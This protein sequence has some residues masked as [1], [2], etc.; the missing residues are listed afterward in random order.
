MWVRGR[1]SAAGTRGGWSQQ[2]VLTAEAR[3]GS[4]KAI[5]RRHSK[6]GTG[7]ATQPPT[8]TPRGNRATVVHRS[9]AHH[10]KPAGGRKGGPHR[11]CVRS[12]EATARPL[13]SG[14]R[15]ALRGGRRRPS[16]R[17][18]GRAAGGAPEGGGARGDTRR[19]KKRSRGDTRKGSH[20][21][22]GVTRGRARRGAWQSAGTVRQRGLAVG[23]TCRAQEAPGCS[24]ARCWR[25]VRAGT[26][27]S[28]GL[29]G[30]QPASRW[31]G[32]W[33]RI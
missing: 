8:G 29:L 21:R 10:A 12:L 31:C 32:D 16:R 23:S 33:G 22:D 3:E 20:A 6:Q 2:K 30:R 7:T 5:V 28:E 9:A 15:E 18:G 25:G 27:T 13:S 17:G 14:V 24:L 1:G 11:A 4:A 26:P 19:M